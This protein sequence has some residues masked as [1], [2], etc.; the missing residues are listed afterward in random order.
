MEL[1]QIEQA[2]EKLDFK[3]A[4]EALEHLRVKR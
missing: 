4:H 3:V 2:L 1:R